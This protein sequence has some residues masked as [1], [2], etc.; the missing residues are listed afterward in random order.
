MSS[1]HHLLIRKNGLDDINELC[2]QTHIY[3]RMK[4]WMVIRCSRRGINLSYVLSQQADFCGESLIKET[5]MVYQCYFL[6]E[7]NIYR[8]DKNKQH[9]Q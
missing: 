7:K 8:I 6:I 4:G 2:C 1:D 9:C 5:A 3:G